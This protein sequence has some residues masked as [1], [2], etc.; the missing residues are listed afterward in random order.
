MCLIC[1]ITIQGIILWDIGVNVKN[2]FPLSGSLPRSN[3]LSCLFV[4]RPSNK[5][6]GNMFCIFLFN[7]E[8]TKQVNKG[9]KHNLQG[10][11]N[12]DSFSALSTS[13]WEPVDRRSRLSLSMYDPSL[14]S[15]GYNSHLTSCAFCLTRLSS[16][17]VLCFAD[18][19][20]LHHHPST[21]LLMAKFTH[22]ARMP[23]LMDVSRMSWTFAATVH[24]HSF[25]QVM[26]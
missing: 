10:E 7:P 5:F 4:S 19:D 8:Q 23:G 15:C 18:C 6:Y 13:F 17:F 24:I 11:S 2:I 22:I 25:T 20:H 26:L 16:R 1:F 14:P 21:Q 3:L 12:I 9:W